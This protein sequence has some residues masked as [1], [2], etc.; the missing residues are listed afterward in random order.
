MFGIKKLSN[1]SLVALKL[2]LVAFSVVA[3]AISLSLL[4]PVFADTHTSTVTVTPHIVPASSNVGFNAH[5]EWTSGDPIHEFRVYEPLEF[6]NLVCDSVTG[7][8]APYYA[9]TTIGGVEYRYCQWNA[10]TGSELKSGN[11]E[12]DFTFSLDTSQTECCRDLFIETR[13]DHGFYAFHNPQICVDTSS[14]MCRY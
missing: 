12:K 7:W 6:S 9:K 10:Q 13:D 8:Y 2:S 1:K 5:V 14:D 3:L 4:V 11:T